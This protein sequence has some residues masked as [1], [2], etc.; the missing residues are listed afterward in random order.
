[1][2]AAGRIFFAFLTLKGLCQPVSQYNCLRQAGFFC[3][4]GFE[5]APS[6]ITR[7]PISLFTI[8][9]C[10]PQAG[11][12]GPS[13]LWKA[14]GSLSLSSQLYKCL[15]QAGFFLPFW[16]WKGPSAYF[17]VHNNIVFA[18]GRKYLAFLTLKGA[19]NRVSLSSQQ[20][21][22]QP[23]VENFLPFLS[24]KGQCQSLSQ[25]TII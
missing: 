16:L 23:Q 6:T 11:N 12:F 2:P 22:C 17:S 7:Q 8:I 10:L 24:L 14:S 5:R 1:M 15:R 13:W 3:L 25:F 18:A 4:F 21:K 20:F 9:W 19:A